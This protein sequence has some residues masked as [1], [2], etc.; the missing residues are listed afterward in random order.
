MVMNNFKAGTK[1]KHFWNKEYEY[2]SFM[3]TTV[4]RPFVIKDQKVFFMLE[5]AI[6]LLGELNAYSKLIPDVD[7]FIEMHVRSEA[8]SSSK[9]E[10]TKTGMDEVLLPEEEIIPERRDDWQEVQNYIKAMNWAIE[11]LNEFPVSERLIKRTHEILLSGV[12]GEHRMP[13]K[14]RK[15]Q[16][17]IGGSTIRTAHFIPPHHSKI[18]ELLSDWEKFWHNKTI[19]VPILI[20]IAIGHYQF[21]TI[22]P[23]LDG[24]GRIGRLLI[25]L[26]LIERCFI[27][28]P[29]LYLS[30]YFENNRQAYYDALDLV[31]QKDD[32]EQWIKFFLEGTITTAQKGKKTFEDI[33]VLRKRYEDKIMTLGRKAPRA[34]RLLLA[35][36]SKPIVNVNQA[37]EIV[38]VNYDTANRLV[39]DFEDLK[40]LEEITGYSRNRLFRMTD[41]VNLF[42]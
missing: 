35:L 39:K 19:D 5:E 4:N 34:R 31:R 9:I 1:I 36:F 38:G 15:S 21:E 29:V 42:K 23:F 12:R 40:I 27:S 14:I 22:H 37:S 6:R 2:E 24:N 20:R 8:V 11:G 7:Y 41:Y 18:P 17:W 30:N 33:L 32:L 10:G 3:P 25:T 13:G 28:K 26:Q 16:N